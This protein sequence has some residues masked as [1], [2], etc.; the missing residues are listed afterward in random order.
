M[1][2]SR[3]K[4]VEPNH[5]YGLLIDKAQQTLTVYEFGKPIGTLAIST[6]LPTA[7]KPERETASGS[8]LIESHME[9][10]NMYG[11]R[12]Q[13]VMRYDGG[14]LLHAVG[15]NNTKANKWDYSQQ[16]PLLGTKASHACVR[17][18]PL[19]EG[20]GLTAFWLYTHIPPKTRVIVLDN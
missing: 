11:M 15:Y 4:V 18:A 17:L 7:A 14:N 12:Y 10:F 6:G 19:S 3:L 5:R 13:Y 9:S 1:P 16:L 8:F 20:D 2:L